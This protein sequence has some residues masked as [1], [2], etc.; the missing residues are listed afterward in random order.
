MTF[1]ERQVTGE[2]VGALDQPDP[3]L[4]EECRIVG[5]RMFKLKDYR[6]YLNVRA[7]SFLYSLEEIQCSEVN[8]RLLACRGAELL[9]RSGV[10]LMALDQEGMS[11]SHFSRCKPD[12]QHGPHHILY[13]C[14]DSY[15]L[16]RE[17]PKHI[18]PKS[19]SGAAES[20]GTF[21][22]SGSCSF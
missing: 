6:Y 12:M 5:N 13:R 14:R 4:I 18:A 9:Y 21:K 17:Q 20:D 3:N 1:Q 22:R 15:F 16:I 7:L 2:N 8:W 10:G 11:L 19:G